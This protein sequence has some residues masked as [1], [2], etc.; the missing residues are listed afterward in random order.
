[1]SIQKTNLVTFPN[2]T[3][4][5]LNGTLKMLGG[6]V[7]VSIGEKMDSM[8]IHAVAHAV[9]FNDPSPVMEVMLRAKQHKRGPEFAPFVGL[10]INKIWNYNEKTGKL[11][12]FSSREDKAAARAYR[13]KLLEV[14]EYPEYGQSMTK[15]EATLRRLYDKQSGKADEDEGNKKAFDLDKYAMAFV[16]RAV[17]EG[18]T[19]AEALAAV[20]K[21]VA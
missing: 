14:S 8:K 19:A 20:K 16:K 11:V 21:A 3:R 17:K 7:A 4:V 18:A 9:K 1:M 15:L 2:M 6:K 12:A 10:V 13:E 5:Q